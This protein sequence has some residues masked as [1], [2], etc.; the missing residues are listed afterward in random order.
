[1]QNV[2][3]IQAITALVDVLIAMKNIHHVAVHHLC[4]IIGGCN[5]GSACQPLM[6]LVVGIKVMEDIVAEVSQ[7]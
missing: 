5:V 4:D 6:V 3:L 2:L 7:P 1:M